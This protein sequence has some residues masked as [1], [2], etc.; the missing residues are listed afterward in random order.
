MQDT[1]SVLLG[2]NIQMP[3]G[4]SMDTESPPPPKPKTPPPEP[5]KE[6]APSHITQVRLRDWFVH[7]PCKHKLLVGYLRLNHP[8]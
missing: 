2:M 5:K 3:S 7:S 1:L 4:D 6:E 8:L